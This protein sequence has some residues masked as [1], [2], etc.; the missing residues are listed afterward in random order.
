MQKRRNSE[1]AM[2]NYRL[3][4]STTV[5][6]WRLKIQSVEKFVVISAIFGRCYGSSTRTALL[7]WCR[8]IRF[9]PART[10]FRLNDRHYV[11]LS[12]TSYATLPLGF[13]ALHISL[14][15]SSDEPV[16][17]FGPYKN[18]VSFKILIFAGRIFSS[19]SVK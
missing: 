12:I 15:A 19:Y 9:L 14:E 13:Q 17:I 16:R 8:S 18:K 1:A 6:V 3:E 7:F 10:N 11:E 2:E 5:A 4:H